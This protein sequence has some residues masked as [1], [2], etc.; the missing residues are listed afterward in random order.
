MLLYNG[1]VSID[2]QTIESALGLL[3]QQGSYRI[4]RA[5]LEGP[6]RFGELQ[7]RTGLL[8]RT[9]SLRLKEMMA[10]GWVT[11]HQFAEV[12][13][14]VEYRLTDKARALEPVLVEV[15]RW[16]ERYA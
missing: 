15:E 8:P 2:V 7:E 13:P 3:G 11:R 14:R 5:L 4:L 16:V 12:P 9:Q 6:L 10:A 1:T